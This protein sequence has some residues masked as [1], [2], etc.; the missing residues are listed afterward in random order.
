[1]QMTTASNSG[2]GVSYTKVNH[3]K[4]AQKKRPQY[5]TKAHVHCYIPKSD[6]SVQLARELSHR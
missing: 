4:P 2:G 6:L 3:A 5:N 1:M